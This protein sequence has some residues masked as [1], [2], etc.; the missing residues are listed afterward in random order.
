MLHDVN[1]LTEIYGFKSSYWN[2]GAK[3]TQYYYMET[4]AL[5]LFEHN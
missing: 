3:Y 4:M 2:I 5:Y 1:I